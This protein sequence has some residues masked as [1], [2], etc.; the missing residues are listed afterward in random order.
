M[1]LWSS[2]IKVLK[3]LLSLGHRYDALT[4]L[5]LNNPGPQ[6]PTSH[7]VSHLK[8][9]CPVFYVSHTSRYYYGHFIR[10][11]FV[12][13][14]HAYPF[15]RSSFLFSSHPFPEYTCLSWSTSFSYKGQSV[16]CKL[17]SYQFWEIN[18][19][20]FLQITLFCHF[21]PTFSSWN[22]N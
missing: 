7:D 6:Y 9:C 3:R 15:L 22:C 14:Y 19:Y 18:R 13:S 2:I 16:I 5:R 21:F 12:S 10:S 8:G 1:E 20:F 11:S 4:Y 17:S